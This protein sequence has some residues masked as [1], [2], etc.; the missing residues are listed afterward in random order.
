[1]QHQ[2]IACILAG[3]SGTRLYPASR[4]FRPKQ[5]LSFDDEKSLLEKTVARVDFADEIL[6]LTQDKFKD[7]IES[8]L[9]DV[10]VVAEPAAKDTGPALGYASWKLQKQYD[11]AVMLVIPSDHQILNK[12]EFV[13]TSKHAAKTAVTKDKLVTLG[14]E[15]RRPATDYGYILPE[16]EGDSAPVKQFV[17]KPN[18]E[19][20]KDLIQKG[21][22]WN[23]GIFVWSLKRFLSEFKQSP[24]NKMVPKFEKGNFESAYDV[25]DPISVD[26][27]VMERTD[28]V[29]VANL[30]LE[31]S[32]LGTWDAV[33]RVFSNEDSD[34]ENSNI[35]IGDTDSIELEAS[36][37][38]IAAPDNHV[39]LID[40]D[41]LVIAA[42]DDHILVAP[43]SESEKIRK[44]VK[45]LSM[46][47]K[48]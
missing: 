35:K 17:E 45:K 23:S 26:Y 6:I 24:L 12:K 39:S 33:G 37:N 42:Y 41:G 40:V 3:G 2:I 36:G 44:I 8:L 32:D 46:S 4:S 30:D 28:H 34:E 38:V 19:K 22:L 18:V 43:R 29:Y 15:P 27:A 9:P 21:A 14:V 13:S 16:Y 20:A 47:D 7:K 11:D 25:V 1:M 31:W 10:R 48:F 5:L